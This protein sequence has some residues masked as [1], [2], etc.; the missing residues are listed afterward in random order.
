MTEYWKSNTRKYCEYCKC[1]FADNRA[2]IDF[3]EMGKNHKDNVQ[4]KLAEIAR[5]GKVDHENRLQ[6][7]DFFRQMEEAALS[8]YKN[9]ISANPD[10]TGASFAQLAKEKNVDIVIKAEEEARKKAAADWLEALST[11]G[12]PYYYH[13]DTKATRWDKPPG[14]FVSI[15]EQKKSKK[16]NKKDKDKKEGSSSKEPPPATPSHTT[17]TS[18]KPHTPKAHAPK[19]NSATSFTPPVGGYGAWTTVEKPAPVDLQLPQAPSWAPA[20]CAPPPQPSSLFQQKT[21]TLGSKDGDGAP[22]FK[23]RKNAEDMK[24]NA[25]ARVKDL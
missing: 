25:R 2:S 23:K 3:H 15:K 4:R 11:D 19:G 13:K 9:D 20:T 18:S 14:G 6:A 16:K 10:M 8:A 21:V 7:N 22:A 24:K 17:H 1:W 5:Q 12:T